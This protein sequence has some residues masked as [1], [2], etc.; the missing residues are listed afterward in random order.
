VSSRSRGQIFADG[1]C[2]D[3]LIS[4]RDIGA[5]V[6]IGDGG[7]CSAKAMSAGNSILIICLVASKP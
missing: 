4:S 2:R 7:F 5:A 3:A 6:P 1:A